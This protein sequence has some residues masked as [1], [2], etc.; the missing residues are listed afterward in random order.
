LLVFAPVYGVICTSGCAL[1]TNT[2]RLV[3]R[4]PG[5]LFFSSALN[6]GLNSKGGEVITRQIKPSAKKK[7]AR[8]SLF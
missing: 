7:D 4:N 6:R 5:E 2:N 3:L 1:Q 8:N